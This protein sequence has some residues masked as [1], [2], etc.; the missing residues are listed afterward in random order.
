M[1]KKKKENSEYISL[2]RANPKASQSAKLE[3][4]NKSFQKGTIWREKDSSKYVKLPTK[5]RAYFL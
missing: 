4:T 5:L 1:V 3:R 2:E